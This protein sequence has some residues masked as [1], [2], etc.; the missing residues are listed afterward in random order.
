MKWGL[1]GASDIAKTRMIEAITLAG[2]EVLGVMSSSSERAEAF[3]LASNLERSTNSLDELLSWDVDAVYISTT[4]ELHAGQA[5]AATRAGKH[6]LSEKPMALSIADAQAMIESARDNNVILAVNHHLRCAKSHQA[7]RDIIDSGEIGTVMSVQ[8]NHAVSLPERLR[9]WR[10]TD[11]AKGPG[12]VLDITVHNIDL[13]RFL[14]AEDLVSVSATTSNRG[15]GLDGVPDESLCTFVSQSGVLVSTHESFNVPFS[16]TSVEVFGS[17]GTILATGVLTQDP[18]G[19]VTVR[20]AAGMR[21]VDLGSPE[22]L[23]LRLLQSFGKAVAGEGKP[24]SDGNDGLHSMAGAL[25]AQL[26]SNEGR[27][28]GLEELV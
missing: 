16:T 18:V 9:G 6:V 27:V 1:I 22:N 24:A 21:S 10:L 7:I 20:T 3:S 14:L 23:Y 8:V 4:N 2:D 15:F 13:V 17:A 26:S 28:V 12:V 5:I 19:E 25:A 11:S